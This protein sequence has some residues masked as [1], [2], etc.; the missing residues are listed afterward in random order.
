M[1]QRKP[2]FLGVNHPS[3]LSVGPWRSI[4]CG[5]GLVQLSFVSAAVKQDLGKGEMTR[6]CKQWHKIL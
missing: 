6:Q 4:K 2:G 1:E 5:E 3:H